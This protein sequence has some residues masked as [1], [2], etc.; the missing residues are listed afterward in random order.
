MSESEKV[1]HLV[2][3]ALGVD[4]WRE[5]VPSLVQMADLPSLWPERHSDPKLRQHL[6]TFEKLNM[7]QV[8][9]IHPSLTEQMSPISLFNKIRLEI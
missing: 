3:T 5:H 7:T 1:Y 2:R 9:F 4:K 8:Q 6:K